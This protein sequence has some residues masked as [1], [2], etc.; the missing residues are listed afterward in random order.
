MVISHCRHCYDIDNDND[1]DSNNDTNTDEPTQP[2]FENKHETIVFVSKLFLM[3]A[4]YFF[5][6]LYPMKYNLRGVY[7]SILACS[8][9]LVGYNVIAWY[10]TK[11]PCMNKKTPIQLQA[12]DI[13]QDFV[14]TST[15]VAVSSGIVQS[16]LLLLFMSSIFTTFH[17]S[18]LK[19][20]FKITNQTSI[21]DSL[22][23]SPNLH[24]TEYQMANQYYLLA[25][26]LHA[27]YA[28]GM[29]DI[30]S[31]VHSYFDF[32][33]DTY[34]YWYHNNSYSITSWFCFGTGQNTIKKKL[35]CSSDE[36]SSSKSIS[37]FALVIRSLFGFF[38]KCI[39][40]R[41]YHA[42]S[43]MEIGF[44]RGCLRLCLKCNIRNFY[45]SNRILDRYQTFYAFDVITTKRRRRSSSDGK[46]IQRG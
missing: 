3:L 18:Y 26:L 10:I 4:I 38:F 12:A 41:I 42:I 39:R 43:T 28:V 32:W 27:T 6:A 31:A 40:S 19:T 11:L 22:I 34:Y 16:I 33:L 25:S 7:V 5:L 13:F 23:D 15:V 20:F 45:F 9:A 24:Y 30:F 2:K 35:I 37:F 8:L 46:S 1:N 14:H 36:S 29:N 17:N 21:T 44:V